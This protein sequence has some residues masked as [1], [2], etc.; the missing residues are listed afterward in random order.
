MFIMLTPD[1]FKV[2]DAWIA[3]RINEEFLFVKEDPYDIFVLMDAASAYVLGFVFSRVVEEATTA[4]DVQ[5]LFHKAW[6][7]KRQW[8]KK[9]IV[10]DDSIASNLFIQ[11]A[12]K[13][14]IPFDIVPISDL[15]PIIEP[16]KESFA[17]H[18]LGNGT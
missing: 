11:E 13:N 15:S 6:A 3:V 9:L 10:S 17:K 1:Q 18:F 5:D 12:R 2:N 14:G 7:A 4:K 16:L 8:A